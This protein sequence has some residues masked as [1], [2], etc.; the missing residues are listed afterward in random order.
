MSSLR[1][2][3]VILGCFAATEVSAVALT[4]RLALSSNHGDPTSLEL[5]CLTSWY[6]GIHFSPHGVFAATAV[7][8]RTNRARN[9]QTAFVRNE[10]VHHF[11]G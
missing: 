4:R 7:V 10:N 3:S 11:H 5:G 1:F 2:V 6:L 8:K 9:Q